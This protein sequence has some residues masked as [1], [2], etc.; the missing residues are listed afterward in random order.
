MR[1]LVFKLA[2]VVVLVGSFVGGWILIDYREFL[3]TPLSVDADG[4]L[5]TVAPGTSLK[6]LAKGLARRGMI[7]HPHYLVWLGRLDGSAHQIQAGEYAIAPGTNPRALLT[8]LVEGKVRLH[9]LTVVEGWTFDQLMESVNGHDAL[10]HTLAGLEDEQIMVR[11]GEAGTHPEGRFL[12]ETYHFPR[13]TRDTEFLRRAYHAMESLLAREWAKRQRGLPL[14][15]ADEALV[16]A[17]IVEKETA[18]PEERPRIAGV[19]VRRLERGMRL[20]TDPTVIYGLGPDFDG[21]IRR[22]DLHADTPYNTY[23]RAGLPPT[24]IAMPSGEAIHAVLHPA[25]GEALYFV[26]KGDGS[27]HFSAT[28]EEHNRAVRKYQLKGGEQ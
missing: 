10:R 3:R 11:I 18:V 21:N 26:A 24:P 8:M 4:E 1:G 28:L 20:Q 16:L 6:E 5:Y 25:S 15:S 22:R 27:H 14:D 19:F 17:S 2:G 23:T 9:A 7:E 12:P 13:G